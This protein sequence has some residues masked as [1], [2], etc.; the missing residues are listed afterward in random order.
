VYT[1]VRAREAQQA[2]R[3]ADFFPLPPALRAFPSELMIRA[4]RDMRSVLRAWP[5]LAA[6]GL[7]ADPALDGGEAT[8]WRPFETR[9][10]A[11][12]R[13]RAEFARDRADMTTCDHLAAFLACQGWLRINASPCG[14][15]T[16]RTGGGA[17]EPR[18]NMQ[19]DL[20][21]RIASDELGFCP[22]GVAIAALVVEGY[23][24]LPEAKEWCETRAVWANVELSPEAWEREVKREDARDA[25]REAASVFTKLMRACAENEARRYEPPRARGPWLRGRKWREWKEARR[26]ATEGAGR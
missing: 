12:V 21:A 9:M 16:S 13:K 14:L 25:E 20:L 2:E 15:P 8:S 24:V 5:R 18:M 19:T 7:A 23:A 10:A 4:E 3:N 26:R 1:G 22:H 6:S 17:G 11:G